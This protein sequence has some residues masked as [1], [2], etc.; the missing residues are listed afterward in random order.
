M[1]AAIA[2]MRHA[3]APDR[4]IPQ[5]VLLGSSLFMP[6]RVGALTGVKVVSTVPGSPQGLVAVFDADGSTVG[7]VDGP[8][9][10]AIRTGAGAGLATDLLAPSDAS[11]MAMLGA[12]AMARDQIEAVRTVREIT[13]IAVWSRDRANA[14]RLADAVGGHAVDHPEEAVEDADIVSTATPATAPLFDA[15]AL[16]PVVHVNAVGAFT[17][18]MA[19]IPAD[20]VRDAYVVV[21][22]V[23]AAA[24]E[25]GDLIQAGRHPD[26]DMATLLA[27]GPPPNAPR[28]LFKSVGIASQDIAAAAAALGV[29]VDSR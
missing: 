19:E 15:R 9:L 26:T 2:A 28:T 4:E 23:G 16:A 7:I 20:F 11:R 25:A 10:T 1:P 29:E 21:D 27:T 6:G 24:V 14:E 18:D 22:D 8:A 5:R 3:F 17:P 12:G 13:D